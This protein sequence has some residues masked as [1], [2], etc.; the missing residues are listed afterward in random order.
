MSF[1]NAILLTG[2]AAFTIPL[3]IHLLNRRRVHVV[4]WGAMHLLQKALQL[5]RRN[6]NL[7]QK[8]L[9]AV[10]ISIPIILALCLARPVFS[11][12]RQLPGMNKSS[13]V[14]VLDDSAS[15]SA[16][17]DGGSTRDHALAALQRMFDQLPKGSDVSVVLAGSPPR[18]LLDGPTASLDLVVEKLNTTASLAGPV[19]LNDALQLAA[20]ELKRMQTAA[21]ELVIVSDFQR[22]DWADL[23]AGGSVPALDEIK[24]MEQAPAMTLFQCATQ[25]KENLSLAQVD[26]SAF[27]AAKG[28]P[29]ALRAR[30]QNHG[31]R[32]Y[33][34]IPVHLE[35][36]GVR[37]RSTR[38]S[39]SPGAESSFSLTHAFDAAG[40]H[41]L[42]LR[43]EGD[44]FPEDNALSIITPVRD[45]VKTLL[46]KGRSGATAMTG[47]TD[48]LEIALTPHQSA[49]SSL[50][51]VIGPTVVEEQRFREKDLEGV[52]II[53]MANVEKLNGNQL[54]HLQEH[55]ANGAGLIIFSGPNC[56]VRWY[57]QEMYKDGKGLLPARPAGFGHVD[58]SQAPARLISQRFTHPAL[59]YFNDA[60]GMNLLDA[61]FNH[62]QQFDKV[63][64]SAR[65]LLNLDRGDPLLIEKPYEQGR[66]LLFAS[67]AN[68]QWNSMPL[69]PAFV[70]LMQ[71]LVTHLA[72]QNTPPAY[73]TAGSELDMDVSREDAEA[74]L[75]IIDPH[76]RPHEVKADKVNDET[77]KL[78]YADTFL[79]GL[80]ELRRK[81]DAHSSNPLRRFAF[82]PN[83]QESNLDTLGSD[84]AAELA[85]KAG[86][87]YAGDYESFQR[88]DRTRRF[89]SEIW[90]P[91]LLVILVLLFAEVFLQQ[92]IAHA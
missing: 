34:D 9:L 20:S 60:R 70:P 89:G 36:D 18:L 28:Q 87:A 66:V 86:A 83:A 88:Q 5:R 56:D 32:D 58:A 12:L 25:L 80:Y 75:Q 33:Q 48:F 46:I 53:I 10:R 24:K 43:L 67:S 3:L 68:A 45:E 74:A 11:L 79:P 51:D 39:V 16:P 6:L 71:R 13:L 2:A 50:K 38:V 15:M 4:Q 82:N 35:A 27:I 55:I 78:R 52:E 57:E 29:L 19:V 49:A 54:K 8:L 14:V 17:G 73:Q 77:Y 31:Q 64:G 40:D 44:A 7:E 81:D 41:A 26:S 65:V 76:H 1:L 21:R 47:A 62:W 85:A 42:T 22:R 37:I 84:E 72:T 91:L 92:R 69:Q 59:V 23:L 30:I 90:Q 61:G 63:E